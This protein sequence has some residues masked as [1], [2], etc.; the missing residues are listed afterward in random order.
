MTASGHL[1]TFAALSRVSV[2]GGEADIRGTTQSEAVSLKGGGR[3]SSP[4]QGPHA[5]LHVT[6]QPRRH[7]SGSL[8]PWYGL[9]VFELG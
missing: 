2:A 9:R 7:H 6:P 8:L 3:V 1:E 4:G 5:L